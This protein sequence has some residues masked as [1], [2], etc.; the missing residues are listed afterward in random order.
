[1]NFT[2]TIPNK[3]SGL[4][5]SPTTTIKTSTSTLFFEIKGAKLGIKE[6]KREI[7]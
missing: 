7:F 6:E 4:T 5:G 2:I 1:M 3:K